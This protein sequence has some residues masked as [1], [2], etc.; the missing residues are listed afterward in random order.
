MYSFE[1]NI[2]SKDKYV[3]KPVMYS[4]TPSP[5]NSRFKNQIWWWLAVPGKT[6]ASQTTKTILQFF[7]YFNSSALPTLVTKWSA[8]QQNLNDIPKRI[9]HKP[10]TGYSHD[11]CM[12]MTNHIQSLIPVSDWMK[13]WWIGSYE[14]LQ[15][16]G[17]IQ[18][19]RCKLIEIFPNIYFL[20]TKLFGH[21][22]YS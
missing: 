18:P 8:F 14:Y 22:C 16:S 19:S 10:K 5:C 20:L 12:V 13:E 3:N 17:R 21:L 4:C 11:Y 9:C 15:V 6:V 7:K 2:P 1:Y